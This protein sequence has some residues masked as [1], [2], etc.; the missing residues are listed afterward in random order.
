MP[1]HFYIL[2]SS[3]RDKYYYGHT[4][5]ELDNRLKKHKSNHKGFTGSSPDWKIVYLKSIHQNQRLSN[6]KC[7]LNL[8]KAEN[9][10]KN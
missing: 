4:C 10:L 8:G 3:R 9:V 2:Y 1:C 6:A 5:D 7:K